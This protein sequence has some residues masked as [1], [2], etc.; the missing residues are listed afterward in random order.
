MHRFLLFVD[1]SNLFG[2]LKGLEL[3]VDDY[4]GFYRYLF[5]EVV[6]AWRETLVGDDAMTARM[7]RVHW[8]VVGEID[9]WDLD[10]PK[11][12][13]RLQEQ[14]D[15]DEDL[16]YFYALEA[17]RQGASGSAVHRKAWELCLAESRRWYEN[18][19]VTLSKMRRFY[20][21]VRSN[22]DF[23]DIA[24][25]GHWKVDLLH[26][27]VTEKGLDTSLAVDMI[28]LLDSYDVA[29]VISGDADM[30][31]SM[32]LVKSRQKQVA[33][34]EFHRGDR[35]DRRGRGFASRL[36]LSADFV[37]HVYEDDLLDRGIGARGPGYR[38]S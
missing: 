23:I 37:V 5:E 25:R 33:V 1:G 34:V 8:Y 2:I 9:D 17:E 29:V 12:Q 31:P 22:T 24:E 11:A 28:A 20:H 14:F 15:K 4:Q 26:R 30:I 32:E 38:G 35:P 21:A 19:R 13:S 18:K 36:K 6:A 16:R 10:D 3:Q 27:M 7:V